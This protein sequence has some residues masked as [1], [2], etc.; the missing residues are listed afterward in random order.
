MRTDPRRPLFPLWFKPLKAQ[1][2]L[3]YGYIENVSHDKHIRSKTN[4]ATKANF[5]HRKNGFCLT[6][7]QEFLA[8]LGLLG[9]IITWAKT[10]MQRLWLP[11]LGWS[12]ELPFKEEMRR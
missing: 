4:R 9:P 12:D 10:F 1:V 5:I 2:C 3:Y 7:L 6:L 11:E 8:P